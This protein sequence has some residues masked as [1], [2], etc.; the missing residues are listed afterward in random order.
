MHTWCRHESARNACGKSRAAKPR[1]VPKIFLEAQQHTSVAEK[2]YVSCLLGM[3]NLTA[4]E[5]LA[6][7]ESGN[8][9]KSADL[10]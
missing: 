4:I 6:S 9:L 1:L 10:P 3:S 7:L 2:V 5:M 8:S